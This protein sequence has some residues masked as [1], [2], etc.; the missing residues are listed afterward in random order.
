MSGSIQTLTLFEKFLDSYSVY[1]NVNR[2]SAKEPF[3]AE[4]VFY[5]NEQQYFLVKAAKISEMNTAEFAFFKTV[6]ILD[7]ERLIEYDKLA[8]NE[9]M[10]RVKP[11]SNHKNSDV[12]L[13]IIADRIEED[14]KALIKKLKHSKN[15]RFSLWGFSNY[16]L[17]AVESSS[18]TACFNRQGSILRK[19]VGNIISQ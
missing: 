8:W 16:R 10:S 6:D 2:D 15:Y 1:Y 17:V 9:G 3:D 5:N 7:K 19:L 13:I 12:V 4:A 18:N 11:D 14:A